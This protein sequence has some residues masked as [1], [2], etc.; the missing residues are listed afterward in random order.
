MKAIEEMPIPADKP[1]LQRFL[2]FA[3]FLAHYCPMFSEI[4]APLRDLLT[5]EN[6]FRWNERHTYLTA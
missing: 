2:G 5:K 4:T 6:K 3:T 1:A